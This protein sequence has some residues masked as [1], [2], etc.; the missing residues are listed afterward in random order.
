MIALCSK[1]YCIK[2]EVSGTTKFSSKGLNK[3]SILNDEN[4]EPLAKYRRV[5]QSKE[6]IMSEN[7]GFQVKHNATHTYVQQKRGLA[8]FYPK[9]IVLD[10][11][12]HTRPLDL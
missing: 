5:L 9:R 7:R 1:T 11:G 3:R 4:E 10:D 8:Y 2:D 12:I 6:N